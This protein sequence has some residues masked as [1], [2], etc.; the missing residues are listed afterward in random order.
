MTGVFGTEVT[1]D[2]TLHLKNNF[3]FEKRSRFHNDDECMKYTD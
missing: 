2:V 3:L 1:V